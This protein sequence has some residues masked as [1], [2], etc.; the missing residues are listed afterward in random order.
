M[1]LFRVLPIGEVVKELGVV[2]HWRL[3]VGASATV[4]SPKSGKLS[5]SVCSAIVS[6]SR[7][8]TFTVV[9]R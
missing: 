6:F 1:A 3:G 9:F 2:R 7:S 8:T 4:A 5:I